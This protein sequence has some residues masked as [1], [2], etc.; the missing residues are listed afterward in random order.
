MKK[1]V[2]PLLLVMG[3]LYLV[4]GKMH[5]PAPITTCSSTQPEK[6]GL[7]PVEMVWWALEVP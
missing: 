4:S 5:Q 6:D 7:L 3:V 2:L 1:F